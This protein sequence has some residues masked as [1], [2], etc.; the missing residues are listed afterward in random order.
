V[1]VGKPNLP[2]LDAIIQKTRF[3]TSRTC[4]DWR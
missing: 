4:Y 2:I 1:V 3:T